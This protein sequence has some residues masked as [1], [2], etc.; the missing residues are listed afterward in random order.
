MLTRRLVRNA[1]KH[2]GLWE[3]FKGFK[4]GFARG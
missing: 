3:G 1:K 4:E 2:G